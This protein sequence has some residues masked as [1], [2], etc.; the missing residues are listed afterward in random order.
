M[1]N[2]AA[3]LEKECIQSTEEKVYDSQE[4]YVVL[5][6]QSDVDFGISVYHE[7][8]TKLTRKEI[9]EE[10]NG[11]FEDLDLSD[12]NEDWVDE[13]VDLEENGYYVLFDT[14]TPVDIKVSVYPDRDVEWTREQIVESA[15]S[16]LKEYNIKTVNEETVCYIQETIY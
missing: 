3:V 13:V 5:E 15:L 10:A 7:N 16:T 9:I 1:T 11:Y 12:V 4:Y 8:Q 14:M 2:N 6:R